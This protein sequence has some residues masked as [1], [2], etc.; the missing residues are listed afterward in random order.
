MGSSSKYSIDHNSH[1]VQI[2]DLRASKAQHPQSITLTTRL[3]EQSQKKIK[4]LEFLR[5]AWGSGHSATVPNLE[6][7][8][9]AQPCPS[10][11]EASA[12]R[13]RATILGQ[14]A[15]AK[16]ELLSHAEGMG[17]NPGDLH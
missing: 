14:G 1:S 6:A 5:F 7:E 16:G 8:G 4:K 3:R 11:L 12:S 9:L 10:E 13:A 2:H 15:D 17:M